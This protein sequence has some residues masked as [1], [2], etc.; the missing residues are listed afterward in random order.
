MTRGRRIL[1]TRIGFIAGFVVVVFILRRVLKMNKL[2]AGIIFVVGGSILFFSW[3]YN[4]N[5]P[6][7]LTPLVDRLAPFFPSAGSYA[8]KQQTQPQPKR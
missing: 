1:W 3:I 8:S 7:F 4:R 6:K 2:I 5:E